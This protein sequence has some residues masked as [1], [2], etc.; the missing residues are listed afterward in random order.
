MMPPR[1]PSTGRVT[2]RN[3][4]PVTPGDAVVPG[5]PLVQEGELAV[6]ELED[7]AILPHDGG[8]EHL[9]LAPHR[10]PQVVIEIRKLLAVGRGRLEGADLQPLSGE[11]LAQGRRARIRQHPLDLRRQHRRVAQ[12]AAVGG[13]AQRR[14][15]H[16][17]PQEIGQP[18][19][20]FVLGQADAGRCPP[21]R[22]H[23]ARLTALDAEEEV[24]R[25]QDRLQRGGEPFVERARSR[26]RRARR[27]PRACRL[28]PCSPAGGRRGEPASR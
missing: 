24:R 10:R 21:P 7:A 6:E 5:Q 23:Q 27:A 22:R 15:R 8:D 26:A 14:V 3:S 9:G 1:T 19:R 2:R 4:L 28:R 11:V 17:G 25:D 13:G 16:A 18:R 12:R 20:Q